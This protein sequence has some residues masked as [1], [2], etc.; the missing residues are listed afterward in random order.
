M[1]GTK[2]NH[3]QKILILLSFFYTL[4]VN[5]QN[6]LIAFS[7]SGA[8]AIVSSV[9]VENLTKNTTLTLSGSDILLLTSAT[10]INSFNHLIQ[11]TH[12]L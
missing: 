10:D 11:H 1:G 12:N 4:R 9:K 6:Y 3:M 2:H 7:G 5:G 8:S